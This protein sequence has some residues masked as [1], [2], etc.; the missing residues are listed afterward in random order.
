VED[1]L[2]AFL[3]VAVTLIALPGPSVIFVVS[4]GVAL[5]RR[6]A[7][8]S[9]VGN[10]SGLLIQA[11][12]VVLGLGVVLETS[13]AVFSAVRL[14][15]A[16]YLIYLGI[17]Q[18]R[19]RRELAA[20]LAAPARPRSPV[21]ILRDGLVVGVTNPKGLLLFTAVLPQFV[22][23]GQGGAALQLFLLGMICVLIAL[24]SDCSWALLAG[25]ARGW[26]QRSPKLLERAG[27]ASG[28]ALAGL[29]VYLA[30]SGE[31]A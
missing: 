21:L 12:I 10:E 1:R 28:I 29:G 30:A 15:G 7:I 31:Q 17:Q 5:G 13:A 24:I 23:R 6:A 8:F 19:H 22:S 14:A 25:A 2:P 11:V 26:L 16:L 9:A 3:A 18:F 27:A 4:R 20:T